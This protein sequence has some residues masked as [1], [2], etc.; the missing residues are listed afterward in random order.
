[1]T[2]AILPILA[3]LVSCAGIAVVGIVLDKHARK[4]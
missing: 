3:V 4:R 2:T 1:M